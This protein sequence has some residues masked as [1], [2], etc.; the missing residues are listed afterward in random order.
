ME[1]VFDKSK[2]TYECG[3]GRVLRNRYDI[4]KNHFKSQTHKAFLEN[5]NK[6]IIN[7]DTAYPVGHWRRYYHSKKKA[8][9]KYYH[10]HKNDV[11]TTVD[12]L[13]DYIEPVG[14][15]QEP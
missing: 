5:G 11:A 13:I 9:L 7:V 2:D 10:T 8:L 6:K 12:N 1:F 15:A 3:C 14:I 4:L